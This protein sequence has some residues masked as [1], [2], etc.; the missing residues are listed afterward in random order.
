MK[1]DNEKHWWQTFFHRYKTVSLAAALIVS[2]TVWAAPAEKDNP[3]G[4]INFTLEGCN[5]NKMK[6]Y[7][8]KN[9]QNGYGDTV[10][11]YV[12]DY[13]DQE[14]TY[15]TGNLGK[16]WAEL[17]YV[18]HRV[19]VVN[20]ST[21]ETGNF[22]FTVGGDF[23]VK[24]NESIF[25]WDQ[26]TE[27]V[28]DPE[29]SNDICKQNAGETTQELFIAK[30]GV[31]GVVSTLYRQVEVNNLLPG[32]VCVAHYNARLA[33]GSRYYTGSSL[34]SNLWNDQL[35]SHNIGQKRVSIPDS[36]AQ[37]YSKTMDATQDQ[38]HT[39]TVTKSAQPNNI[40]FGDTCLPDAI[41]NKEV[42]ITVS[43]T[44]SEATASGNV[45]VETVIS[46]ENKAHR[47]LTV[48]V[49]DQLFDGKIFLEEK[50][51]DP[52]IHIPAGYSGEICR[53]TF[54]VPYS[55]TLDLSD[56]AVVTYQEEIPDILPEDYAI[57]QTTTQS[58]DVQPS[59]VFHN[60]LAR[61]TDHEWITSDHNDIWYSADSFTPN[62][63][64]T[65]DNAYAMGTRTQGDVN[66]TSVTQSGDKNVV[67]TKT[68][69]LAGPTITTGELRD[70]AYLRSTDGNFHADSGADT[71]I[72]I[73]STATVDL[74]INKTIPD[75]LE[76]TETADFN[77]TVSNGAQSQDVI[78]SFTAGETSDGVKV[79]GLAPGV[80]TV[81]ENPTPGFTPQNN[82]IEVDLTLP[83]CSGKADFV[84][85]LAGAPK[86]KVAK[87]TK[88]A[89]IDGDRQDDGWIMT[90]KHKAL[91]SSTWTT[92]STLETIETDGAEVFSTPEPLPQG[93]YKIVEEVR[94]GW[95]KQSQIG[96]C[97]FT[98]DYPADWNRPDI[99]CTMTNAK[100]AKIIIEKLTEPSPA[101]FSPNKVF[102]F[103]QDINA[104]D[105]LALKDTEIKTYDKL[106]AKTYH[107]SENDPA[108]DFDLKSISC[109]ETGGV[110][111]VGNTPASFSGNEATI[112]L[113]WGETA[114]CTF[115]NL[116]RGM[117]EVTK[118][119][120][121]NNPP[122][123]LWKF[124]LSGPGL[125]SAT[126]EDN[127]ASDPLN[128]N[129]VKLIPG[130]TYRVC[131]IGISPSWITRWEVDSVPT[132]AYNPSM[133]TYIPLLEVSN[134]TQCIDFNA[135]SARTVEI[136]V[137]NDSPDGDPRTIG[138]WKNWNRCTNGGQA[139]T[140]DANGGSV[141]GFWLLEDVLP[142]M[143]GN[144][145]VD[146]CMMG[147]ALLN[148][149][150]IARSKKKRA[151]DAAYGMAAQL[152]A[153]KANHVAR[154]E[155]CPAV[156]DAM[157]DADKLLSDIGFDGQGSYLSPKDS[158]R[159]PNKTLRMEANSLAA[160]LDEY[161]N[162]YL[163]P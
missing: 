31:G 24:N 154:A 14:P 8:L 117:V 142:I 146:S 75:I 55:D 73:A 18:P 49:V 85:D 48:D 12:C 151:S 153:A 76:D 86:V 1:N 62:D 72:N 63:I 88:P 111:G 114:K 129:G 113:D 108:P 163:C 61:V 157:N 105:A 36:D 38:D 22:V 115:T 78:I 141:A 17:D 40:Q 101:I 19:T 100:Y 87:V 66:W 41:L 67:F 21:T 64:G 50:P 120:N 92:M 139:D 156:I 98:I 74:T 161:N 145:N 127:T 143:L 16:G 26:I 137:N 42:H 90:L 150:D 77:F 135:A 15:T 59:G 131:E 80:Y 68:I 133:P 13:S 23:R 20:Q 155:T 57:T 29:L 107:V 124:T 4:N 121:G 7:E 91:G 47:E 28:L 11:T 89:T 81:T 96:E 134:E 152:L 53:H 58:A 84:N 125:P 136:V 128:F 27:L 138:Y 112:T 46:A 52:N 95:F 160:T 37:G 94:N 3:Y 25:G 110:P 97:E 65:F 93:E 30:P 69:S 45:H 83:T 104:S 130:E 6:L 54:T 44:K 102:S 159:D 162:G 10:P 33:I 5:I 144:L 70:K 60:S 9:L 116:E 56:I 140:A 122:A 147:T 34:Q 118:Y 32:A 35:N 123:S 79:S 109:V 43:W 71:V 2:S 132:D 103:A 106:M 148:K 39:W 82:P 99:V 119:E 149:T 158:K 126:I 51:C